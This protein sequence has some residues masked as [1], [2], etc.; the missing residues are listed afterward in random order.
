MIRAVPLL[1]C[2]LLASCG[3]GDDDGGAA[4]DGTPDACAG[5]NGCGEPCAAG[6]S[7]GVGMYCTV[8]GGECTNTPGRAAPFCTVD[9]RA[10]A[11][12]FCTRPCDPEADVVA[13]CGEDATCRGDGSGGGPSGCVP[14][15][16][17]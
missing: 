13:Q 4:G 8:G 3:G 12:A 16:C 11:D 6:N 1:L 17:L 14:N 2:L 9:N 10:D 15:A 7:Y 5:G